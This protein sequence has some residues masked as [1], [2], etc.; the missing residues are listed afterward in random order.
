MPGWSQ[1]QSSHSAA[2]CVYFQGIS[3]LL[4]EM[5]PF[6]PKRVS[7]LLIMYLGSTERGLGGNTWIKSRQLLGRWQIIMKEML[8]NPPERP[9]PGW[10]LFARHLIW[11]HLFPGPQ[12]AESEF[13]GLP[14]SLPGQ[15]PWL[16][17]AGSRGW[18]PKRPDCPRGPDGRGRI[19][20]PFHM[21]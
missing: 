2:E 9:Q 19:W 4:Q 5:L 10:F 7:G 15:A 18:R 3:Y 17:G 6:L 8:D 16:W 13:Q 14:Y 20:A 11:W 1:S 21:G 12:G